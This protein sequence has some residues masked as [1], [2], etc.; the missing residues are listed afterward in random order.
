RC[1]S[2]ESAVVGRSLRDDGHEPRSLRSPER[3]CPVP[4]GHVRPPTSVSVLELFTHCAMLVIASACGETSPLRAIAI[5]H[6][7]RLRGLEAEAAIAVFGRMQPTRGL[8]HPSHDNVTLAISEAGY[9]AW[10]P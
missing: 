7:A 3:C 6:D 2:R 9:S 4:R 10:K 8:H 1:G 5:A